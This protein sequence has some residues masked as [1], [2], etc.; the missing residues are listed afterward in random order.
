MPCWEFAFLEIYSVM[1]NTFL[2]ELGVKEVMC[3]WLEAH[4]SFQ[5]V[6][7]GLTA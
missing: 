3:A 6:I 2:I 7:P 1:Q 4:T 5:L